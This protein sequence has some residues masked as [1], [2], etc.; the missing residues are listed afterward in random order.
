MLLLCCFKSARSCILTKFCI[1]I[2]YPNSQ[3]PTA[4]TFSELINQ[5]LQVSQLRRQFGLVLRQLR[6]HLFRPVVRVLV[7]AVAAVHHLGE[8]ETELCARAAAGGVNQ[9][10]HHVGGEALE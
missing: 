7:L 3:P 4:L 2:L 1:D 6:N 10:L 9:G 8:S 5:R